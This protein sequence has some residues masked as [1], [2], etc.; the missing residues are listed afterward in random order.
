MAN[1]PKIS[2][3]APSDP[4]DVKPA[5]SATPDRSRLAQLYPEPKTYNQRKHN[6]RLL[7]QAYR[8]YW[9]KRPY[10]NIAAYGSVIM[11]LSIWFAQ[12]LNA[13][14][15]GSSDKGITMAT[16]FFTFAMGL[17]LAFLLIAWVN[18]VNKQFS[19]FGGVTQVFWLVYAVLLTVL[20]VL[21]LS[22]WIWEYTNILWIPA[23]IVA[24]FITVFF[25]A[26]R[27]IGK[28]L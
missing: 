16:V 4:S 21:W 1:K 26:W 13:W 18:Y 6:D 5:S 17:G 27:T 11:G 23:L 10:L 25:S 20:L 28:I 2:H 12:N 22:G 15:F 7:Q 24:H 9:P 14:W 3:Y 8:R 19:Y